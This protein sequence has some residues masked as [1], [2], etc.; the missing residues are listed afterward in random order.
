MKKTNFVKL[1]DV[2]SG[3]DGDLTALENLGIDLTESI[4]VNRVYEI[5][6]L[7]IEDNYGKEGL[8][9]FLWFVYE[10]QIN[11]ELTAH[12]ENGNEIL[13]NVEEL[14]E[15]LESNHKQ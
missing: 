14:Y 5:F 1:L 8:E 13:R 2:I 12:D 15:Y 9:W 3:I 10:K 11:P 7:I 4:I 6:D